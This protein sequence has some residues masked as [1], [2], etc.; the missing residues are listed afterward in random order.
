V[1]KAVSKVRQPNFG[2]PFPSV[3]KTFHTVGVNGGTTRSQ[4]NVVAGALQKTPFLV[5]P[6]N[7]ASGLGAFGTDKNRLQDFG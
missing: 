3:G 1:Q 5:G 4:S 7:I 6:E 2:D